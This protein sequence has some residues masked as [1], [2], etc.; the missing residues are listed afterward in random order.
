[1]EEDPEEWEQGADGDLVPAE[2]EELGDAESVSDEE[3][4][5]VKEFLILHLC[6]LALR[7][8]R[9]FWPISLNTSNPK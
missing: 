5:S 9:F 6:N 3:D 4:T 2:E 1:M 8:K 7:M